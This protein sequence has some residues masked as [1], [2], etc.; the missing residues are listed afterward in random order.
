MLTGG[1][2]DVKCLESAGV[3]Y[4]FGLCGHTVIGMMDP[5]IDTSIEFISFRHEQMAAHAADGYF[6]V[7]HKPAVLLTHLGPGFTNATT[8]AR[9]ES[10][11]GSSHSSST[12]DH[13][14]TAL[15][16]RRSL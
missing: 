1:E 9:A 6:R 11:V 4:V 10:G 14:T 2:I 16:V 3:E 8:T 7:T 12:A 15:R 13:V 5:L